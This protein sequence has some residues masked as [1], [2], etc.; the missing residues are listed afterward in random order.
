MILVTLHD[1]KSGSYSS[2]HACAN[3]DVAMRDLSMLVNASD[4]SLLSAHPEDY[5][6]YA[7]GEWFDRVPVG[8]GSRMTAQ[9]VSY[10]ELRAIC[11]AIDLKTKE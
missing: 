11:K 10:P 9:L 2:P 5:I 6:L 4:G 7:A 3:E 8:D 1:V